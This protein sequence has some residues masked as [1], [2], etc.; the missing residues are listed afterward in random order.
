MRTAVERMPH[1]QEP[2]PAVAV[3]RA[4]NQTRDSCGGDQR[5]EC[6]E[7][8]TLQRKVAIRQATKRASAGMQRPGARLTKL[9]LS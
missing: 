8:Q 7:G 2:Y 1:S 9:R 4:G 6:G 3:D 5:E